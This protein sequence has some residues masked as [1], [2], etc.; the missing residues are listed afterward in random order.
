MSSPELLW[1]Q[2]RRRK[3]TDLPP[4]QHSEHTAELSGYCG[5]PPKNVMCV[6]ALLLLLLGVSL[7]LCEW[8]GL[9]LLTPHSHTC[10]QFHRYPPFTITTEPRLATLSKTWL[11]R[12]LCCLSAHSLLLAVEKHPSGDLASAR[13]RRMLQPSFH[14]APWKEST[15]R[16]SS[17]RLIL[18]GDCFGVYLHWMCRRFQESLNHIVIDSCHFRECIPMNFGL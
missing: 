1:G 7:S 11:S 18:G 9:A 10:L 6:C 5:L 2:R 3:T 16:K 14:V 12:E 13:P 4:I 8:P 15:S 17:L